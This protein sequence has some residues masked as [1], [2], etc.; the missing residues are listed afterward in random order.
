VEAVLLAGPQAGHPLADRH[1]REYHRWNRDGLVAR[2]AAAFDGDRSAAADA[3]GRT[4][5][6]AARRNPFA[7]VQLTAAGY[8]DYF[9]YV[10]T[11]RN[12]LPS[13][14]GKWAKYRPE[15]AA[16]LRARFDWDAVATPTGTGPIRQYH[17]AARLWYYVLLASPLIGALSVACARRPER[18]AAAAVAAVAAIILIIVCAF[19]T[20]PNM[21]YLCPLGFTV[22]I[23]GALV[24]DVVGRTWFRRSAA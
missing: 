9:A 4:A 12:K 6:A 3:A 11:A 8:A 20:M 1:E 2:V 22:L 5:A 18:P 19:M 24:L 7:V 13:E 23:G 17:V 10:A 14:H 16:N 15:F 21:R